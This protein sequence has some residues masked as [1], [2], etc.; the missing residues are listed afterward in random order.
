ML[1]RSVVLG[2]LIYRGAI[3]INLTK[4]FTWT[5][6]FLILVAGG[7]LA[8]GVHDLQ[9]AGFLPGLN[10]LAFDVSGT[11]DINSWWGTLLK[12]IFNFSP[13]TTWLEAAAWLLYVIP[14]MAIFLR[15]IRRRQSPA[16]LAKTPESSAPAAR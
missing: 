11:V 2:Y 14:V 12:G 7:V 8:Y 1:F 3:S 6:G 10:D 9:E 16:P 15:V 5:G 13:A 4:F